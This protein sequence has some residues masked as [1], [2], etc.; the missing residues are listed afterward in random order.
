MNVFA[1]ARTPSR[2]RYL[3]AAV[4]LGAASPAAAQINFAG[5]TTY[6]FNGGVLGST[7]TVG[8]L[9]VTNTGFNVTTVPILG[10]LSLAS[11][12]GIGNN[13]GAIS[14]TGAPTFYNNVP[15]QLLLAFSSPT[16]ANQTFFATVFGIVQSAANGGVNFTFSP[17]TINNIPFT[18]GAQTG[19][20]SLTV[21][22]VSV[23]PGQVNAQFTGSILATTNP[24][25][26]STPEP[27]TLAMLAPG[28]IG[29]LGFM[30]RR[31]S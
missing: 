20:Y 5:N 23:T 25:V 10:N 22:N 7:A 8:G 28:V 19:T 21:N 4:A 9:T 11:V 14:L 26:T 6:A 18:S 16:T 30:R 2:L 12:G 27:A 15:F 1:I 31:R 3:A 24:P 17:T 29:A 13:F